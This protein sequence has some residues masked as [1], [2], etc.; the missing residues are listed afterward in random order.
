MNP[1]RILLVDDN[2]RDTELLKKARLDCDWYAENVRCFA[3]LVQ[4]EVDF[5][6]AWVSGRALWRARLVRRTGRSRFRRMWETLPFAPL[7]SI[8]WSR[9]TKTMCEA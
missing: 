5:Q 7:R 6:P 3:S 2:P 8:R 4:P 9:P 1:R